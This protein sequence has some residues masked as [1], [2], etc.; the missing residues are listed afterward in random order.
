MNAKLRCLLQNLDSLSPSAGLAEL[1]QVVKASRITLDDV[2]EYAHFDPV[3]Y[4]RELIVETAD[5]AVHLI[6][7]LP[8]QKSPIHNHRGSLCCVKVLQ[9]TAVETIFTPNPDGSFRT[10]TDW[11]GVGSVFSGEDSDIHTVENPNETG[12]GLLT[13]HV[14]RPA[15]TGMEL[16]D[17]VEGRLV[18]R[19]PAALRLS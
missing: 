7:W 2:R 17:L 10:Y 19:Q 8:L 13:M 4:H 11:Y 5:Y 6:G 14:Y 18:V 12:E 3:R 9:A 1:V 15:L 16:F